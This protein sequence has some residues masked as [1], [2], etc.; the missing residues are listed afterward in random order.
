MIKKLKILLLLMLFASQGLIAQVVE[1]EKKYNQF[2]GSVSVSLS[3]FGF[4]GANGNVGAITLWIDVPAPLL[5]WQT[6]NNVNPSLSGIEVNYVAAE[7]ILKIGWFNGNGVPEINGKVLDMVFYYQ[8]GTIAPV[9][10]N[11]PLNPDRFKISNKFLQ[12]IPASAENGFVSPSAAGYHGKLS[13]IDVDAFV[14]SSIDIP[15]VIQELI[16]NELKQVN[17]I[18]LILQYDAAKVQFQTIVGNPYGFTITGQTSGQVSMM[19]SSVNPVDMSGPL[20]LVTLRFGLIQAGISEILFAP[21]TTVTSNFTTKN[22]LVDGAEITGANA[23]V[24]VFLQGFYQ[25]SETMRKAKKLVGAS[26]VDNF[27]G[28]VSDLI[29]IELHPAHLPYGSAPVVIS[30]V[31]LQQNGYAYYAYPVLAHTNYYITVKHRNHLETVSKLPVAFNKVPVNY[32]FTNAASQAFGDNQKSLSGGKFGIFAGDITG[33]SGVQDGVINTLD[34]AAV[35]ADFY[36]GNE[37]YLKSDVNANGIV[38]TFDRA[39]V[40]ANF[41]Q[42]IEKQTP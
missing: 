17:S 37:G 22:I 16:F 9:A 35:N 38:N 23:S 7:K 27:E 21:G 3:M 2:Q 11:N 42:G 28:T 18:T 14:G 26:L 15:V 25:G 1:I 33:S 29:T 20:N 36:A 34:R 10:F 31:K 19:W 30:N 32:D 8:G 40:N 6:F 12:T 39:F 24:R 4:T 13:M 5:G 41:Y